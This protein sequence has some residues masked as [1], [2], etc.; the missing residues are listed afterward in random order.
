MFC[1][2]RSSGNLGAVLMKSGEAVP[3]RFG[4]EESMQICPAKAG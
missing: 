2:V 1:D 4:E 3:P